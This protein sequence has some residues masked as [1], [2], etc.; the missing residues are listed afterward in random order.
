MMN[1]ACNLLKGEHD[2]ASFC[3]SFFR[4]KSTV[5]IV[6][7]AFV[8]KQD[9]DVTFHIRAKSFLPHQVRNIMGL[10]VRL[11]LGKVDL[12]EYNSVMEAKKLGLAGPT[13]P[14]YGLC[15]TKINYS[16]IAELK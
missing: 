10:L 13:A 5:R 14:A 6:H 1:E 12:D 3:A 9:A 2:F 11:G 16:D 8:E 7:D 4:G 15:L